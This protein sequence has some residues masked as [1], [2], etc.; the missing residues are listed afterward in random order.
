MIAIVAMVLVASV[1]MSSLVSTALAEP[2]NP[3]KET[4][5]HSNSEK[6]H[7]QTTGTPSVSAHV[8]HQG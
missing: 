2:T 7:T 4:T 5:C 8:L 1:V 6:D 3:K